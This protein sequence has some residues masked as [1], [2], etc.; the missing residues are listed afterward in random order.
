[1]SGSTSENFLIGKQGADLIQAT[2][3]RSNPRDFVTH[4]QSTYGLK[5]ELDTTIPHKSYPIEYLLF[6]FGA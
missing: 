6:F 5:P 3:S 2:L 1:M 4:F